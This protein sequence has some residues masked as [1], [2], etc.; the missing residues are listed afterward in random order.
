MARRAI[1]PIARA[2]GAAD[3]LVLLRDGRRMRLLGGAGRGASWAGTVEVQ[4]SG[5]AL[6]RKAKPGKPPVRVEETA[7]VRIV[8]PYWSAH[9]ALIPVG[10]EH[11]V[12][13]GGEAPIRASDAELMRHAAEAVAAVGDV[14]SAK[15]LADEL[16]VVDAVR[17]LMHYRPEKVRDTARHVAEVA[18]GALSC[19]FAAVMVR[20][21]DGL[22]VERAGARADECDDPRLCADMQRL[23]RRVRDEP[24]VEQDVSDGAIGTTSGLVSRYALAI[25]TGKGRAILVV[26]HGAVRPRGFTNLC[27][28][29]G[30]AIADAAEVLLSQAMGREELAAE[31]DQFAREA[32]NDELTGLANRVAWNEALDKE[33]PRR[34]RYR[35]PVVVMSVDVDGLKQANDRYGHDAGDDLLCGVAGIL[36]RNLRDADVVARIGGDEFGVLLPETKPDAM[37]ALVERIKIACAAWRGTKPDLRL[38]V[39]I[40][41]AAPEPFGDLREALRTADD[42]MYLAKRG[43]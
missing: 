37:P 32:R 15:L 24:L 22:L 3:V 30:R 43:A 5:E 6:L 12:V 26:G 9:A 17:Q 18:A 1:G 7:P 13:A 31:R 2:L 14:S 35:R 33:R 20:A 29:V 39:S 21:P 11:V 25:G 36:R 8:G 19:E 40:G 23:S 38:S 34:S 16:E 10:D 27:L 4:P 41:W 28:R 42:R